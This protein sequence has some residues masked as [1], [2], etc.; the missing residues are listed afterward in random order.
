MIF[1]SSLLHKASARYPSHFISYSQPGSSNGLST[2]VASIGAIGFGYA[3]FGASLKF[4]TSF[5]LAD[6]TGAVFFETVLRVEVFVGAVFFF[7]VPDL[8]ALSSSSLRVPSEFRLLDHVLFE[9][10]A[11][12]SS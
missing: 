5:F 9:D 1:T 12:F 4:A 2:R 10:V 3:A 6:L 7:A 11:T 8:P